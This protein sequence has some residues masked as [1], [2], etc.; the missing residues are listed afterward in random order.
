MNTKKV[1]DFKQF[2]LKN[3][4][5]ANQQKKDSAQKLSY[6]EKKDL[7]KKIRKISNQV[8]KLEK[9]VDNLEEH[10]KALDLQLADSTKFKELSSQEGFFENYKKKQVELNLKM[11]EWENSITELDCL[12]SKRDEHR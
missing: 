10:L 2:E 8:N 3:K 6:N 4:S 7:D 1:V 12:K 11:T 9:E 5:K